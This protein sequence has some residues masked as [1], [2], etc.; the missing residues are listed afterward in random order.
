V[1]LIRECYL[2]QS[3]ILSPSCLSELFDPF[4][5]VVWFIATLGWIYLLNPVW[6]LLFSQNDK[7]LTLAKYV[8]I[9]VFTY[10]IV[11]RLTQLINGRVLDTHASIAA[12]LLYL[13]LYLYGGLVRRGFNKLNRR[14]ALGGMIASA[15]LQVLYNY[16]IIDQSLGLSGPLQTY[17]FPVTNLV[18]S[19]Y[20][21]RLVF[22]ISSFHFLL[23]ID[24]LKFFTNPQLKQM[25]LKSTASLASLSYGV[26]LIHPNIIALRMDVLHFE[27]PQSGLSPV[28]YA[29]TNWLL[30]T[31]ISYLLAF[32]I[33]KT[34]VLRKIIG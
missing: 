5:D 4:S 16:L 8:V 15:L 28:I 32:L 31:S 21:L 25:W 26:Y 7:K 29:L 19:S 1:Y 3:F 30:V 17:L 11:I 27:Y 2:R 10:A 14:L 6:Q 20:L 24:W 9:V 33:S 23:T 13:G 12:Q 34:P 18:V 22:A